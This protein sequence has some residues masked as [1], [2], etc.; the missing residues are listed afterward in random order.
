MEGG[1]VR[2]SVAR[3]NDRFS[4]TVENDT[5]SLALRESDFFK[6]GHAL[7]NIRERLGLIY[8]GKASID[9]SSARAGIDRLYS[10]SNVVAVKIEAPCQATLK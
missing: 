1:A 10:L 9:I 4:L 5:E 2:I 3:D 6:A 7:D 8:G